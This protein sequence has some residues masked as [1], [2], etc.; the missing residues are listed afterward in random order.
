MRRDRAHRS[1]RIAPGSPLRG[2]ILHKVRST[3]GR[4]HPHSESAQLIV[5]REEIGA[6]G[7]TQRINNPLRKLWHISAF[8]SAGEAGGKH[9]E[10]NSRNFHLSPENNGKDKCARF[11]GISNRQ[12]ARE[13]TGNNGTPPFAREGSQVRSLS[14]PPYKPL[15]SYRD[16]YADCAIRHQRNR[17]TRL[18]DV[19]KSVECVLAAF[20]RLAHRR[21]GAVNAPA[22]ENP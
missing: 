14:R 2:P 6:W 1:E 13:F 4:L 20:F 8:E 3:A 17:S 18:R 16:A 9:G 19:E 15:K 12:K 10:A 5:P 7:R 22:A 21:A 11:Q